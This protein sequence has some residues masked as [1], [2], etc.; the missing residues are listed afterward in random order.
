MFYV[1]EHEDILRNEMVKLK[2]EIRLKV[3]TDVKVANGKKVRRCMACDGTLSLLDQLSEFSEGKL[4][5]EEH[6]IYEEEDIAKKYNVER[7]PTILFLNE[8]DKEIIRYSG[9]PLGA[10]TPPFIQNLIQFSGVRSYYDDV[11]LENLKKVSKANIKLFYTLTCPYCPA[12]VPLLG[13]M[14]MKS[15]G[16]VKVDF[17]DIDVNQ[18]LAVK[19][20]VS[21]VPHAMINEKN[22]IYGQFTIQDLID[23]MTQGKRDFGGMYA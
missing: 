22:H 21:G 9:N 11:I 4:K 2:N 23:K 10:E 12:V 19:Y 14:A 18:D 7:I 1:K 17:I 16:K 20:Q 15:K 5:I 6:S 8:D 13:L 3:F